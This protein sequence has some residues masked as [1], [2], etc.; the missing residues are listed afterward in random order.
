M[1]QGKQGK[2]LALDLGAARIGV[3][4]SD[5]ER[6]TAQPLT[7]LPRV[8]READVQAIGRLAAREKVVGIVVGLPCRLSGEEGP[9]AARARSFGKRLARRLGL[10]V[11]FCDESLTSAEAHEL[12]LA[13]DQSRARRRAAVDKLAAAL[14][15]RRYLD[16]LGETTS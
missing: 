2:L 1:I 4:V 8:N 11:H 16:G 6:L 5:E 10:A 15:L 12:L 3:A 13:A 7:V 14:I 9:E